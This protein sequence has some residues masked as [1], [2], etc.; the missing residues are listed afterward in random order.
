MRDVIDN[1]G[2]VLNHISYDSFGLVTHETNP[3]IDFRFGYTGRETDNETGLMYYR[4][5]YFDPAVG[6]FVSEDPLGFEAGDAN[7]YRYVFNSPINHTDPS[8]LRRRP[9][10]KAIREYRN[11]NSRLTNTFTNMEARANQFLVNEDVQEWNT[12]RAGQFATD[13]LDVNEFRNQWIR[14]YRHVIN[15]AASDYDI[16]PVLLAA[17][18]HMEVAGDPNW[19]DQL[20]YSVRQ[21]PNCITDPIPFVGDLAATDPD[22]TS[23]GALSI[24]IGTAAHSLGFDQLNNFERS[25]IIEALEEP[26][27]NLFIA[28]AHL[29]DLKDIYFPGSN[30]SQFI[31]CQVLWALPMFW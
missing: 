14:G 25:Q 8:G 22:A 31:K 30:A 13:N 6:T 29:S 28:A 5:R 19:L 3:D 24:Q 20:A 18:A 10:S 26:R 1:Q 11:A 21:L 4:A 9:S 23:F 16:P 27:T 2:N 7:V 15:A 17:V 12:L